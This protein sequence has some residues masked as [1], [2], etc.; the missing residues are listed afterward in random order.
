[1]AQTK[2]ISED[3]RRRVVDAHKAGKG[4][5]TISKEFGLHQSTVRQTVYKL[6]TSDTIVTLP[7]SG[8]TTEITAR[9]GM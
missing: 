2:D 7:R 6:K 9:A 4:Y 3:L 8:R 1:M 5:K